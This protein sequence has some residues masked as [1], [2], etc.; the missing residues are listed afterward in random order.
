MGGGGQECA[1][2]VNKQKMPWPNRQSAVEKG[3]ESSKE[4]MDENGW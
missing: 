1:Q 4:A 2:V 3:S